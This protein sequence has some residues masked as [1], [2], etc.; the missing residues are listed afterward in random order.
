MHSP[1]TLQPM[2]FWAVVEAA[3]KSRRR[4]VED[5]MVGEVAIGIPRDLTDSS[6][7]SDAFYTCRR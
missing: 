2:L 3:T 1:A 6:H 5:C 4:N 7:T